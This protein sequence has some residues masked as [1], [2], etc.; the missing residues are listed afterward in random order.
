M[1]EL[2]D[3]C[4]S[5]LLRMLYGRRL[6][7]RGASRLSATTAGHHEKCSEENECLSRHEGFIHEA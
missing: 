6:R 3:I 7:R 5:M 2:P 1:G 4:Q